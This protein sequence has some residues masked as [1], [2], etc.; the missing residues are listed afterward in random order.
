MA[1]E[2][3]NQHSRQRE[4]TL[5]TTASPPAQLHGSADNI[6]VCVRAKPERGEKDI[7]KVEGVNVLVQSTKTSY[8][9][10]D[11]EHSYQF[12]FDRA[13]G[14]SSTNQDIFSSAVR[15][16]VDFTVNGGSGAVIAYGQTGTGKTFTLLDQY[17]GILFQIL[18]YSLSKISCGS[19]SFLEIYMGNAQDCLRDNTR[20]GL[21]EKGGEI[22]ASEIAVRSFATF[23]E[24]VGILNS[25]ILNRTTSVTDANASSSRSHAVI[26]IEY[27]SQASHIAK[28]KRLLSSHSLAVV[29]LAGSERGCDRKACSKETAIE[30]AEINKSLLALKECIRGIEMKSKFLPFR[31]SKL[32][33]ILKSSLVGNSKTCFI[34]NISGNINDIEHTLNT[35]RYASRIKERGVKDESMLKDE[36]ILKDESMLKDES[37]LKDE[38]MLN[39]SSTVDNMDSTIEDLK[40]IGKS[41]AV[42]NIN[43]FQ[44]GTRECRDGNLSFND[45]INNDTSHVSRKTI[46]A[47]TVSIQKSKIE[48]VLRNFTAQVEKESN[49]QVLKSVTM[50]LEDLVSKLKSR[51]R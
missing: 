20:V 45:I 27:A 18:R 11:V 43:V 17:S 9:L 39:N 14:G 49:L 16:M 33:Q 25:G 44:S 4:A 40:S 29:D 21:F 22:Y 23:E 2:I 24:A 26:I 3:K 41:T 34:A 7:V 31:Q 38:D 32:T 48:D 13:F 36:S 5:N 37:I 8:T 35:L 1:A 28:S 12:A 15:S 30:G 47:A 42:K 19:L 51:F 50:A 46:Q 10:D 6:C